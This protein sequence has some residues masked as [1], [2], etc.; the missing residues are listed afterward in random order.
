M[1]AVAMMALG[2]QPASRSAEPAEALL[3]ALKARN[4][5]SFAAADPSEDGRFVAAMVVGDGNLFVISGKYSQPAL[6]RERLLLKDYQGAYAELNSASQRD[7]RLFVQD[8]AAPGLHATR[9]EDQAFDIAY[10]SVSDRL[11]FDGDWKAQKRSR[12]DY[13][14][15]YSDVDERYATLLSALTAA[16]P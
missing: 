1:A 13:M 7:G 9:E 12:E 8:L 6:L 2:Q 3:K 14:E 15:A 5:P 16:L 11:V 4:L 10:R